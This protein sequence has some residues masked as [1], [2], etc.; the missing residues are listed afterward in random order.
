[1]KPRERVLTAFDHREPDRVPIDMGG[2]VASIERRAYKALKEHLGLP[3]KG[4]RV[5]FVGIMETFDDEIL[6]TFNVDF[7]RV[8]LK[9]PKGWVEKRFPDGTWENEWGVRFKEV[10]Y[11]W[12][13]VW[14]RPLEKIQDVSEIEKHTW[15]D[16]DAPGRVEGLEAEAR[17]LENA[18]WAVSTAPIFG[19]IFEIAWFLRGFSNFIVDL[20][21]RPKLADALLDK[22]TDIY[23][24]LYDQYLGAVGDHIQM[25][26]FGDDLGAQTHMLLS[27]KL[28]REHIK[29]R[30]K[31]LFDF[32]HGKTDARVFLHSCGTFVPIIPD[33]IEIGV[34]VL[35][36]VQPLAKDMDSKELKEK[37]GQKLTFHGG[38][39]IQRV[40]PFG[41]VEEVRAEAKRRIDALAPGGGYVFAPAHNIQPEIPPEKVI[42][43]Y[44][45]AEKYGRYPIGSKA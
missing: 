35:N 7:R 18:G 33:L 16:L 15:P 36:P 24:G 44:K 5:D 31:R 25:V 27:P 32:I 12:E 14:Y 45:A 3:W 11:Y 42:A 41:S 13:W 17:E 34:D 8:I 43:M 39:D 20:N 23:L 22:I 26:M 19:G 40:L 1:L 28:F 4:E 30:L 6:R 21:S 10:G 29:P 2:T 38:V 9:P 37:F